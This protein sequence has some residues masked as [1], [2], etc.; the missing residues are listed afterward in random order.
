MQVELTDTGRV[1]LVDITGDGGLLPREAA[2]NCAGVVAHEVL[3]RFGEQSMGLRMRLHKGLP[4]GSGLG[5]SAASGVAA[6]FATASFMPANI[7]KLELLDACR[8][9]ECLATGSPHPDNRHLPYSGFRC[10]C[11][12]RR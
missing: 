9:G 7:S 6:A 2:Q 1:E 4:L 10:L 8:E 12:A 5:S 11:A 3:K